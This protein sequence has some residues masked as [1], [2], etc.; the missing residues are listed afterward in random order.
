MI[1]G[2]MCTCSVD[3]HAKAERMRIPI[4]PL[5]DVLELLHMKYGYPKFVTRQACSR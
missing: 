2:V 1:I 3:I 5:H 4:K